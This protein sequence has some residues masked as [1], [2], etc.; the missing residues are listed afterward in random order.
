MGV[1]IPR[2]IGVVHLVVGDVT[3]DSEAFG[4][5]LSIRGFADSVFE[6]AHRGR[7]CVRAFIELSVRA[8]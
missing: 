1:N 8:L 4:L 5:T 7:V 2:F 3:V 6:D